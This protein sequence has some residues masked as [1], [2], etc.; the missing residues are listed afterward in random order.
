M[1]KGCVY[2]LTNPCIRYTYREDGRDVTISPV[3]IGMAKDVEKRL[4]SLNT[5]LP[6]NF[7]HHISVFSNDAKALENIV[8]RLLASYRIDTKDGDRTE[9]FRCT[10]EEA[11]AVLKQTA[12]DM[13]LKEHKIDK[14]KLIGRS[15]CKIKANSRALREVKISHEKGSSVTKSVRPNLSSVGSSGE[16]AKKL[17]NFSFSAV[18]IPVGATL[19]FTESPIKVKV[20]DGKNKVERQGKPYTL[21]GFVREFH[22]HPNKSGAYQGPKFFTYKGQL[23]VELRGDGAVKTVP[24]NVGSGEWKNATQLAKAIADK[25][26]G[27]KSVG[28]LWQV[29]NRRI[30]VR[31][32]SKWR[33]ILEGVGLVFDAKDFV[34]DWRDAGFAALREEDA[35][36]E[37]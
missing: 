30:A 2:V 25:F 33:G 31:A 15:S 7:E 28:H 32:N 22:P 10:V 8:H 21:S 29:L 4:G 36:K 5:S 13:H 35:A 1:G 3:K 24:K 19:E 12:K 27:G 23:L 11:V 9:F 14:S 37:S 16:S 34:V 20:L 6:E 17:P 18:G 26:N